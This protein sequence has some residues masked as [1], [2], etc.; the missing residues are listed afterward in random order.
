MRNREAEGLRGLRSLKVDHQLVLGGRLHRQVARF[1]SL[2]DAIDIC[3]SFPMRFDGVET[4]PDAVA[5][6]F[7]ANPIAARVLTAVFSKFVR[8][9][10]RSATIARDPDW[11]KPR[12]Y[13]R[14]QI[15]SAR[16][17]CDTDAV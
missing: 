4:S 9:Q 3:R 10:R 1:F 7:W 17:S 2:E 8:D 12:R 6:S 5:M 16:H 11:R 13:K 15:V 14:Y